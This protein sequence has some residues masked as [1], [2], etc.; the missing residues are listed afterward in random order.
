ML[1]KIFC[2]C[3]IVFKLVVTRSDDC[4]WT[5]HNCQAVYKISFFID[6]SKCQKK[7]KGSD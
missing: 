4:E 6:R 3:G 2:E 1:A 5:C 7:Q